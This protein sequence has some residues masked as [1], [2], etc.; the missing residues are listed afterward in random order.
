MDSRDARNLYSAID[1]LTD[2]MMRVELLLI[3]NNDQ[4]EKLC[5]NFEKSLVEINT[6]VAD[7]TIG[8][9]FETKKV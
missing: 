1:R 9:L 5:V 4:L 6:E 2:T 3:A 7:T 8:D